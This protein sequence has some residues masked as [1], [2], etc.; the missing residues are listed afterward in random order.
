VRLWAGHPTLETTLKYLHKNESYEWIEMDKM[1]ETEASNE[2][3][4]ALDA[5]RKAS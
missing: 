4:V 3:V 1:L 2:K 5:Y